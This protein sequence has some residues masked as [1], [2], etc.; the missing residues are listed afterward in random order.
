MHHDL[1]AKAARLDQRDPLLSFRERFVLPE[2]KT[3][4]NGNSLGAMPRQAARIAR[5]CVE[6]EWAQKLIDSWNTADWLHLPQRLGNKLAQLA[7]AQS[8]EIVVTDT[9]GINLH[10]ALAAALS[11]R[12][13]RT[14]ILM[15][16][17]NFP[18]NN[19]IAEGIVAQS[20]Q[21]HR[22]LFL[23]R[24]ELEHHINEDTAVICLTHVHY[25][26]G[27][28]LDMERLTALAH[29]KG[30]LAV[31]DV[32]HSV[33]VMPLELNRCRVD[34]AVGCT[35]KFLN[36][37]PGS[38]AFVFAAHRHHA[39]MR[40]PLTGWWSH[41]SPF[42]F[43]AHYEA[44]PG[45]GQML[46]GTQP[47][48]SMVTLEPGLDIALE[49]DKERVWQKSQQLRTLFLE[50]LNETCVPLGVTPVTGEGLF[51]SQLALH[52]KHAWPVCNALAG[53]GIIADFRA[54]DILRFGL[55]PLYNRYADIIKATTAL[56]AILA[57]ECWQEKRYWEKRP[58]T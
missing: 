58:V 26:T 21:Q 37:G 35:Y 11:L 52:H 33:G 54:P 43:T 53:Q 31:W 19:Y 46:T 27:R 44:A 12:P 4:L 29:Q 39:Q 45:I 5:K 47:V 28:L 1:P 23:E 2:G 49:A 16:R 38:P 57:T 48:I 55:S 41:S 30:A 14:T 51:A 15:E 13:G 9:T 32:C 36:G 17:D 20:S 6:H 3:Y 18:H 42:A 22:L 34:F 50:A 7:G 8:G 40:Q 24:H 10:K 25:K 56:R